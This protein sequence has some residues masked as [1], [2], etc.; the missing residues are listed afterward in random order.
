M[1]STV[2][3]PLRNQPVPKLAPTAPRITPPTQDAIR[4]RAHEIFRERGGQDDAGDELSD[5]LQAERETAARY[6]GEQL[7]RGDQE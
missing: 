3:N 1:K 4:A 6:R 7:L 2:E 5:W